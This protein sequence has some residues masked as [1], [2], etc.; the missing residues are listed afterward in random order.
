MTEAAA[1]SERGVALVTGGARRIG[2]AICLKLAQAGFDVAIHHHASGDDA[3]TLA[4]EIAVMYAGRIIETGRTEDVFARMAHPYARGLFAASPHG[5]ALAPR[6][7]SEGRPRLNAIPGIVPDPFGR[8]P[9]CS[10]A[11]RCSYAQPDCRLAIPALD[12]INTDENVE[13]RA[14][15]F[16]PRERMVAS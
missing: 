6:H 10:F 12:L 3:R 4:D 14:A 13:H 9:H 2:R 16:H 8:P 11:D 1:R 5:A 7:P 15:C